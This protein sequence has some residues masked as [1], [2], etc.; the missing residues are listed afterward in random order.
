MQSTFFNLGRFL[1]K[2]VDDWCCSI[3]K[4]SIYYIKHMFMQPFCM[5]VV[6]V[7]IWCLI[8]VSIMFYICTYCF[9]TLWGRV[10]SR[11]VCFQYYI[12][13]N[14]CAPLINTPIIYLSKKNVW[15]VKFI[16]LY[17]Y[18]II[19]DLTSSWTLPNYIVDFFFRM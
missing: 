8:E 12:M 11:W 2:L 3:T 1:K 4:G 13:S 17:W 18:L 7:E 10:S 15:I 9:F 5:K 14:K 16:K 6:W 19:L